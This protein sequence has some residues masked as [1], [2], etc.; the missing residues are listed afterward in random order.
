MQVNCDEQNRL[1]DI[2]YP[3]YIVSVNEAAHGPD[4]RSTTVNP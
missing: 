3:H 4:I 2:A 1:A